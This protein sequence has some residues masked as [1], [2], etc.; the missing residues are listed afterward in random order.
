MA[1]ADDKPYLMKHSPSL[2]S[3]TIK[4][5]IEPNSHLLTQ[6]SHWICQGIKAER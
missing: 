2:L 4:T 3:H 5:H 6:T 1:F